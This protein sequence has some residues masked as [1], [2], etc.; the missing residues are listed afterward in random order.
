MTKRKTDETNLPFRRPTN[1]TGGRVRCVF[2]CI[3]AR[4]GVFLPRQRSTEKDGG[5]IVHAL[6]ARADSPQPT[7]THFLANGQENVRLRCAQSGVHPRSGCFPASPCCCEKTATATHHGGRAKPLEA[8]IQ[9]RPFSLHIPCSPVIFFWASKLIH[10][11]IQFAPIMN[12]MI[13]V[14]RAAQTSTLASVFLCR[15]DSLLYG[16]VRQGDTSCCISFL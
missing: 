3:E 7:G 14:T 10:I 12:S 11:F 5:T 13:F 4:N 8:A 2:A 1:E 6:S 15:F 16:R 9:G